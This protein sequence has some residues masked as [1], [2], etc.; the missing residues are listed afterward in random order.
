MP[1]STSMRALDGKV[2]LITGAA[3]GIGAETARALAQRGVR[4]VLTDLDAEPLAAL[5]AELGEDAVHT[6]VCDVCDLPSME[7]AVA[8]GAAR[9]GG[10]DL[11]LANAG[12][13]SYGS[14][15]R[16]DPATFRRVM[17]INV[18]G[19]FHTVR[20]ALPS[21]IERKG[22]ILVVSSLAAFAPA[23]G[24]VAYNASKAGVEH[25]ATA[26]RLEVAHHG[27]AVGTAHPSWI[28]TPLVRDAKEDL[29]A[30]RQMLKILPGPLK[31]TTSVQVCVDAFVKGLAGRKR[32]V[33]VPGW[34]GALRWLKPVITSRLGDRA[35]LRHTPR[36]LP[37]MD[38][39]VARLGRSTSARNT[40]LDDVAVTPK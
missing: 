3:R 9:F 23:P 26:L 40:A 38:E 20:A 8:E 24:L 16:V 4:L 22:Y 34:V 10:I 35:T 12:I 33:N 5:A 7:R 31:R 25:F 37:L 11:V 21:V 27:V 15:L 39:E 6:V 32:R 19:V 2:A 36:L 30:F 29:S 13:A 18:L 1:I 14:V 28:D 17:D